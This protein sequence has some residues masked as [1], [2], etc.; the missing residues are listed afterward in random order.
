MIEIQ[1]KRRRKNGKCMNGEYVLIQQND[2]PHANA[3]GYV[4][5]AH[6]VVEKAVGKYL[7][8]QIVVH[9]VN[10][11]KNDDR[12]ENLVACENQA[13]HMLL[14]QRMRALKVCGHTNWLKCKFCKQYDDPK[15]LYVHPNQVA[16][17]HR[18]C[19]RKYGFE[20]REIINQKQRENYVK[21]KKQY[22]P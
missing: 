16:S 15:N 12:P 9:H 13:Y 14:H 1:L 2:H 6:L 19:R 22:K 5:R 17:W 7:P 3:R 20:N 8:K 21:R 10:E 18:K 4:R 11:I